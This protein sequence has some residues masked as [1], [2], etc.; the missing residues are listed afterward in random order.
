MKNGGGSIINNASSL[1]LIGMPKMPAYAASKGGV[2]ALTRQL[3][4]DYAPHGIGSTVSVL[5][6]CCSYVTGATISV[7][8]GQTAW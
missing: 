3:A 8:G 4:I 5:V 2:I 6:R 1:R 7:D